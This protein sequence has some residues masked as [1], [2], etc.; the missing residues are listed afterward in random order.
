MIFLTCDAF[1]VLPPV[2]RLDEAQAM[3]H[4]L[5]GY[6]AKVAGTERGV[7]EP[8]AA[9]STC[10]AAP[11]M[12]LRPSVYAKMLG[13]RI[14]RHGAAVWLI[15]TGWTGG[16]YGV[17]ERIP[18]VHTRRMVRAALS[19]ELDE[20]PMRVDS[21]F[22]V[23]VP[24]RVDGVPDEILDPRSTWADPKEYDSRAARLAEMFR[25]N[26]VQFAA[27]ASDEVLAAGPIAA[28]PS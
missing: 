21:V 27:D 19:G 7:T 15:N 16:P 14:G 18:L 10:F 1:G 8:T 9:F 11:F 25:K 4:F 2:S 23:A 28:V 3:Y 17:G 12:P 5:S 22:C 13:E 24:E 20:A 26:F 6:T